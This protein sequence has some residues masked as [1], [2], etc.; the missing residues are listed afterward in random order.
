MRNGL[1]QQLVRASGMECYQQA[2]I[3]ATAE[4]GAAELRSG[5]GRGRLSPP[6]IML[7]SRCGAF[8][9]RRG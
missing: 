4:V 3:N 8:G 1:V 9:G 7:A 2:Q 6:V 5:D